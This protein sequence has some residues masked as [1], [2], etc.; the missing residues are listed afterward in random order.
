MI[1]AIMRDFSGLVDQTYTA[2][3]DKSIAI[4]ARFYELA[5][6]F[7]GGVKSA[8]PNPFSDG[9]KTKLKELVKEN[10]GINLC[11][12]LSGPV[13]RRVIND[14]FCMPLED[15]CD[16]LMD[17]V[18]TLVDTALR[19]LVEVHTK[20][21]VKL[22]PM[23]LEKVESFLSE[24]RAC[25]DRAVREVL[26]CEDYAF[27]L[28]HFYQETLD[29]FRQ[30]AV[31]KDEV[32]SQSMDERVVA[33][34]KKE[35]LLEKDFAVGE[36]VTIESSG[37]QG[38]ITAVH[39]D[40]SCDVLLDNYPS[41][42]QQGCKRASVTRSPPIPST[43]DEHALREM[44]VSLYVYSQVTPFV[45]PISIHTHSIVYLCARII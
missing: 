18:F 40:G 8:V 19:K 26:A 22:R 30:V 3:N 43:Q 28:N 16:I 38:M 11:N 2:S 13:F 33:F 39:D 27:T 32:A 24:H 20:H 9:E 41:S 12:F 23:L 15:Q 29:K 37:E 25:A 31:Q 34:L 4:S 7:K 44:Q 10:R 14:M 6:A 45:L 36:R 1:C 5:E 21:H 17:G 42:T 35:G